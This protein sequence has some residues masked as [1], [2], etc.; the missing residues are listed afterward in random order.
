VRARDE[1]GQ[2]LILALAFLVFF[3]LVIGGM[4]TFASAS[5][6]GTER[7]REQ[8]ATV[9]TADGAMDAAIQ[10]GRSDNTVGLY[11]DAR[12][13]DPTAASLSSTPTLLTIFAETTIVAGEVVTTPATIVICT[14][15]SDF[16]QRDRTV[17]FTSFDP[18][19]TT[20]AGTVTP[21]IRATVVY[22]DSGGS[23]PAVFI[24][25]WTYCGHDPGAT[26]VC[27]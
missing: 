23:P 25:S 19:T 24:Q 4:L 6:L 14:W 27:P 13:Q 21:I 5:V 3:G 8:R 1:D 12:C 2:V 17:T 20:V 10:I 18:A 26:G 9:Y 16:L 7:L 11:G 15:S 22:H